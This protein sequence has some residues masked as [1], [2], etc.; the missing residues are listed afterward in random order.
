[1]PDGD[2]VD[3]QGNMANS[4][5][6]GAGNEEKGVNGVDDQGKGKE[7]TRIDPAGVDGT[8]LKLEDGHMKKFDRRDYHATLHL[9]F[10]VDETLK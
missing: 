4:K 6:D 1:L 2:L 8:L 9:L 10:M 3:P 7:A 5:S